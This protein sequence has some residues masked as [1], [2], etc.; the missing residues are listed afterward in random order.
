VTGTAP[1]EQL[2]DALLLAALPQVAFDGWSMASLSAGAEGAGLSASDLLHGFPNGVADAV[3][4]FSDWADRQAVAVLASPDMAHLKTHEKISMGVWGRLQ[5]MGK[6]PE[7]ARKA[8]AW[9][10][11]PR[12]AQLAARLLYRTCDRLWR[13][14]GDTATDFNFYSKRGLLSGV[15]VSTTLYWL[16]DKS[17]GKQASSAFLDRRIAEVL[18]IG[19]RIGKMRGMVDR[20]D[21]A[22]LLRRF[23][24]GA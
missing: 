17:E 10:A 2:K 12:N 6:W 15:V 14:A 22:V 7:A 9:L 1:L 3:A 19:G 8:T 20:I 4:H 21:P 16:N 5:A 24:A 23:R 11:T 13:A 18:T